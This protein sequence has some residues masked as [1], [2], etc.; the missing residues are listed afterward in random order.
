MTLYSSIRSYSP[1]EPVVN[2]PQ[3]E[4]TG[5]LLSLSGDTQ[6]FTPMTDNYI[7][8]VAYSTVENYDDYESG[9]AKEDITEQLAFLYSFDESDN[10]I[11][12][13]TRDF[14]VRYLTEPDYVAMVMDN[15]YYESMNYDKEVGAIYMMEYTDSD[16]AG[17]NVIC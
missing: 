15:E 3:E 16:N 4:I 1:P 2:E 7:L 8:A 11:Q 5:E 9:G 10:F 14:N 6:Y 17:W 12:G 13:V